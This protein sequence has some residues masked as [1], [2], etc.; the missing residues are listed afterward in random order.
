M[1]KKNNIVAVIMATLF[2]ACGGPS[3]ATLVSPP[4]AMLGRLPDATPETLPKTLK[5]PFDGMGLTV[6]LWGPLAY[7]FD[8]IAHLDRCQGQSQDPV[9]GQGQS[10]G[11]SQAQVQRSPQG[12]DRSIDSQNQNR[13]PGQGEGQIKKASLFSMPKALKPQLNRLQLD[14][15][16]LAPMA[17]AM[18]CLQYPQDCKF[19]K[20]AFRGGKFELSPKRRRDL[21]EVNAKVNRSIRPEANTEGLAGEKWLINPKAGDCNDY[22]V[23]KQ[24]ELLARGWPS[25][26]LLLAEVVTTWGEHHLILV[27]RTGEGDFILD[28]LSAQVRPWSKAAYQWVRVQ[29]PRNP[30]F[31]STVRSINA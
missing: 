25:R 20:I 16:V 26:T 9:E 31:W 2:A 17:H 13:E 7:D 28:N 10:Q 24:H 6:P 22:A 14:K 3:D 15:F 21:E 12:Q 11:Q 23:S 4:D 5:T 30:R 29:S 8:C 1:F 18:F 27:V 19:Q